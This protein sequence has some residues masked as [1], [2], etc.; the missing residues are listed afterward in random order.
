MRG[1]QKQHNGLIRAIFWL[2]LIVILVLVQQKA[3]KT[4]AIEAELDSKPQIAIKTQ[5]MTVLET[6]DSIQ[7]EHRS[8]EVAVT[9]PEPSPEP[10][11][12]FTDDEMYL[13]AVLLSGSKYVDGD[14]EY[15]I[16]YGNDDRYDQISLVLC[17]VMNRV[18][19]D[20]FPNNVSDVV[21]ADGQFA[22]MPLWS[23]ELPEVSDV[24]L[25]RVTA[26]CKAYDAYDHGA[27]SIPENHIYFHGDGCENHSRP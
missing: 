8:T 27:Q 15:D 4:A 23:R 24:S 13:L 17:V 7:V 1:S 20:R 22:L 25:Q 10:R 12:G 14:G 19:D 6:I 5:E 21:W 9:A 18:R 3:S 11:Y 26:W 2:V 16:D